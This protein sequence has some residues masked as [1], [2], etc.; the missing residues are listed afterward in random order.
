MNKYILVAILFFCQ[1]L[2]G[3]TL[4]S[5]LRKR[6]LTQPSNEAELKIKNKRI[7]F[8]SVNGFTERIPGCEP[9][10]KSTIKKIALLEVFF[11]ESNRE[12]TRYLKQLARIYVSEVNRIVFNELKSSEAWN[13]QIPK[14]LREKCTTRVSF[15]GKAG[16]FVKHFNR[17]SNS[18]KIPVVVYEG[19]PNIE[20]AC[21]LS[22]NNY[23][24]IEVLEIFALQ[25]SSEIY[26]NGNTVVLKN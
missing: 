25:V 3:D 16:E 13:S 1:N 20:F 4:E 21:S 5:K 15:E 18:G 2:I 26:F 17:I 22:K 14:N 9:Y 6:S 19:D 24:W 11:D 7:S 8:F 23:T 10:G 12:N